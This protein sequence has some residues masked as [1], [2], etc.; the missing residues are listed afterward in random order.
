MRF[1][2]HHHVSWSNEPPPWAAELKHQ[3]A[4]ILNRLET[5][6]SAIDDLQ[7]KADATLAQVTKNTDLDAS[8]IAIVTANA[9]TILDLKAQLAS[10]GVDPAKLQ[11]LSDTMDAIAAKAIASGQATADAVTANTEAA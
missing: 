5:I 7:A 4:L 8:I 2:I 11:T 9:K 6:M 1:D 3:G 10:A